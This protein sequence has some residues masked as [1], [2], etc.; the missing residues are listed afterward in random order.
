MRPLAFAAALV[1]LAAS[2]TGQDRS[3]VVDRA[4]TQI[5][6]KA[7]TFLFSVPGRFEK[8]DV[9]LSGDPAHPEGG[10]VAISITTASINTGI[11]KRDEHLRSEDFLHAAKHPRITFTS[12]RIWR[13]GDKVM[14]RGLL[15]LHGVKKELTLPF[16]TAAGRNGA[17]NDS[18]SFQA[19][20]PLNRKDFGIGADS[21]AARISL[22]DTVELNLGFVVYAEGGK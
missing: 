12:T 20:L 19:T 3:V 11:R 7:G 13:E 5:G 21:I 4:H 16:E 17:G 15:D 6:F 10:S 2:L 9:K 1:L 18:W 14:V 8:Y 22:K